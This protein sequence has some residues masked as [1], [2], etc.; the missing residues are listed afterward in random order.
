MGVSRS[1]SAPRSFSSTSSSEPLKRRSCPSPA[2]SPARR[3]M[4]G[5]PWTSSS[6][7]SRLPRELR[8]PG[9][10]PTRGGRRARRPG[11]RSCGPRR[12]ARPCFRNTTRPSDLLDRHR[13]VGDGGLDERDLGQ[14][15]VVRGEEDEAVL[16]RRV[17]EVLD[18]SPRDREPV[19]GRRTAADFVQN[20]QA[21]GRGVAHDR[22]GLEHLD[23]ER[24]LPARQVVGGA[25]PREDP[26]DRGRTPC[27]EAGTNEPACASRT[28]VPIC[29][30]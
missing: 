5:A 7:F 12:R 18:E 16:L 1:R 10:G 20:D 9:R 30:R 21:R 3:A 2:L 11:S 23:H 15:V 14:L 17:V 22:R 29:R 6:C 13:R 25:D 27:A 24:R 28:I 26:V 19:E 8:A 4:T